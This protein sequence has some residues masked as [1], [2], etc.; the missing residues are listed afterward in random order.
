MGSDW[1]PV[2]GGRLEWWEAIADQ[3]PEPEWLRAQQGITTPGRT[4]V[5]TGHYSP[6]NHYLEDGSIGQLIAA[7]YCTLN[8][9]QGWSAITFMEGYS[10]KDMPQL[11]ERARTVNHLRKQE[12]GVKCPSCFGNGKQFG[13]RAPFAGGQPTQVT[14]DCPTCRGSGRFYPMEK[15]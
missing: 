12:N 7:G 4:Y 9:S 6:E 2:P 5:L 10:P 13:N 8:G 11:L 3:D 14:R 15:P 1:K